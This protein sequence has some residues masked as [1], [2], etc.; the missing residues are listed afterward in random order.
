M[1]TSPGESKDYH[2]G[3][4]VTHYLGNDDYSGKNLGDYPDKST[5]QLDGKE[6]LG[7]REMIEEDLLEASPQAEDLDYE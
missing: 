3:E 4:N 2:D 7:N 1:E 6:A 5:K